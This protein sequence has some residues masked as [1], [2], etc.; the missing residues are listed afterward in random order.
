MQCISMY[1]D[2]NR[3]ECLQ[4]PG[5]SC[6]MPGSLSVY[7]FFFAYPERTADEAANVG[8]GLVT[9]SEAAGAS[10]TQRECAESR[11]GALGPKPVAL[12]PKRQSR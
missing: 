10:A 7:E 12:S 5:I 2:T 9:R 11:S 4:A 8:S 3:T 1:R 6:G